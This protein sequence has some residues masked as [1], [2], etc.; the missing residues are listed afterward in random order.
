[1]HKKFILFFLITVL[2]L[3]FSIN[4]YGDKIERKDPFL[5]GVL[6]W[7]M[8]GLGQF[9]AGKYL[10]G[11][12]FWSVENAL[13]ISAVLTVADMHFSVNKEIGFQFNIKPKETISEKQTK[14]GISLFISFGIFHIYNVVD[15]IRTVKKNNSINKSQSRINFNYMNIADNNCY[16]INY[17]F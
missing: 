3:Q 6:S 13:F 12:I 11:A 17:K 8:P 16:A 10:K 1:M 15:A 7:Y 2:L 4:A 9:Y 14:I 5:A